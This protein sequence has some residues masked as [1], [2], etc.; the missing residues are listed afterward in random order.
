MRLSPLDIE[1]MEFP[2]GAGGYQR[3]HVRDFLER[4]AEDVSE[5]LRDMQLL[6]AELDGARKR[7]SELQSAEAELQRAVIAAERIGNEL[8]ENAKR[9]AKVIIAEAERVRDLRLGEL[10]SQVDRALSDLDRLSRERQ[11]FREQFRGLLS[12][13]LQSLEASA[14]HASISE[15]LSTDFDDQARLKRP[16]DPADEFVPAAALLDV[17]D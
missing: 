8:K 3:R 2:R 12:A 11:L 15:L 7:V 6:Q 4:V 14:P 13:Y 17:G 10:D 5:L 1:H 9:E 16:A